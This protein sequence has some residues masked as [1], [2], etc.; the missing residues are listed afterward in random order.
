MEELSELLESSS[1]QP[2]SDA[3]SSQNKDI[4]GTVIDADWLL[5]E[6]TS[7][8]NHFEVYSAAFHG[9]KDTNT[10]LEPEQV[11]YQA[12]VYTLEGLPPNAAR[13]RRRNMKR[14]IE[15]AS[16]IQK[17]RYERC[18]IIIY[19]PTKVHNENHCT[20]STQGRVQDQNDDSPQNGMLSNQTLVLE[21][22]EM[23]ENVEKKRVKQL[24][25]RQRARYQKRLS[26]KSSST[27]DPE[28]THHKKRHKPSADERRLMFFL[29]SFDYNHSQQ[30]DR[31]MT[32]GE[33]DYDPT[34]IM[35]HI[36]EYTTSTPPSFNDLSSMKIYTRERYRFVKFL[37]DFLF[38]NV[39]WKGWT[40]S[41]FKQ[42]INARNNSGLLG[43][44][45]RDVVQE[46]LRD[47]SLLL[48]DLYREL[49]RTY[50]SEL[51][52]YQL[53]S[54]QRDAY[55]SCVE[56]E[57]RRERLS[58]QFP[59]VDPTLLGP[60]Q[61]SL[62]F[63]MIPLAIRE[64]VNELL[65]IKCTSADTLRAWDAYQ[66]VLDGSPEWRHAYEIVFTKHWNDS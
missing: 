25:R 28:K 45:A 43:V 22:T 37:F 24:K 51:N 62:L 16:V 32:S 56:L 65:K 26:S 33:V 57:A 18:H 49:R 7:Y 15:T 2:Q 20:G 31:L 39:P 19:S 1:L 46:R 36:R 55:R 29:K 66:A 10:N 17:T 41:K 12:R 5:L 4:S 3:K 34:S 35:K 42:R 23:N 47:V 40:F 64:A 8:Q 30:E 60:A 11:K 21:A 48:P 9:Q 63:S 52:R 14:F 58:R 38:C 6:L 59:E 54:L 13:Y 50:V 44:E 61:R 27:S 53:A